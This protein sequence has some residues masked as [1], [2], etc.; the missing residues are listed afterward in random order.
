MKQFSIAITITL[1]AAATLAGCR[2]DVDGY[3]EPAGTPS[4]VVRVS[5]AAAAFPGAEGFARTATGGRGGKVMK[6]T[7]LND[8]GEGSFRAAVEATGARIVIF[9]VGGTINLASPLK[10]SADSITIAGQS[11]P[12]DGITIRRYPVVIAANNVVVRYLRFRMGS[13]AGVIANALEAFDRSNILI[14]HCSVSWGA[15]ACASFHNNTNFTMQWCVISE[16]LN[17]TPRGKYGYGGIW[18]GR[19]ASFHHNL[20]AHH[21]NRSPRFGERTGSDFA[22]T[23]LVDFR[24]NVVYN[25]GSNS[26]YGGEGMNI[27]IVNNYYKPG[28][29]TAAART[30]RIFAPDKNLNVGTPAYNRWGKFFISG[31]TV[32]GQDSATA[33]NWAKGVYNQFLAVYGTVPDS[34]KT[35][36]KLAAAHSISNNVTTHDAATAYERVLTY[37]GAARVRDAVDAR[38]VQNVRDGGFSAAGSAGSMNGII[39]AATDVGGWPQLQAGTAPVDSDGDGMPDDWEKSVGLDPAF[40]NASLKNLSTVYDNIEVYL[41][42]LVK[43]ISDAQVK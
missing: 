14:D 36:M 24:N 12:G 15:D 28:P 38:V 33:D 9:Q 42:S 16:S 27:N 35:S 32:A 25:W 13:E 17:N 29:A 4:Y 34:A 8:A 6:V 10:I 37:A 11:A 23:D 7:N 31:N 43:P 20:I 3:T 19:N 39:D 1:L 40:S 21:D 41:A 22:L 18:G 30:S 2:K 26:I 5:D